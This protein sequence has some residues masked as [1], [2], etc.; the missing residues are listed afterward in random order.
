MYDYFLQLT[1]ISYDFVDW[2]DDIVSHKADN[3]RLVNLL[4]VCMEDIDALRLTCPAP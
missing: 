4:A 1:E 3:S 2:D